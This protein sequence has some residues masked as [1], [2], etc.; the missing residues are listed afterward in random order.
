MLLKLILNENVSWLAWGLSKVCSFISYWLIGRRHRYLWWHRLPMLQITANLISKAVIIWSNTRGYDFVS[1]TCFQEFLFEL[2]H[3]CIYLGCSS[4]LLLALESWTSSF[5][6]LSFWL[7][8][9][10]FLL[11]NKE[12]LL[13][14]LILI[15]CCWA[16]STDTPWSHAVLPIIQGLPSAALINGYP[17]LLHHCLYALLW[18]FTGHKHLNGI[19]RSLR[20]FALCLK[21]ILFSASFHFYN[22][23]YN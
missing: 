2:K 6:F 12:L 17:C 4:R 14:L 15:L 5:L 23:P 3:L 21:Y 13:L 9:G 10:L 19:L 18:I 22:F 20:G 1:S 7:I 11:Q 8:H 16:A